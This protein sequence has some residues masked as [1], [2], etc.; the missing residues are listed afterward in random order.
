MR[1][2]RYDGA[3]DDLGMTGALFNT[4]LSLA[5]NYVRLAMNSIAGNKEIIDKKHGHTVVQSNIL[6]QISPQ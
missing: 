6:K 2:L 4:D 1:S 5:K 3:I